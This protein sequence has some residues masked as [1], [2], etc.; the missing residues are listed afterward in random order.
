MNFAPLLDKK[1]VLDSSIMQNI[2][3]FLLILKI[4]AKEYSR[5]L[6]K[7]PIMPVA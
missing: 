2:N 7:V 5:P 1:Y 4:P 6:H 3:V